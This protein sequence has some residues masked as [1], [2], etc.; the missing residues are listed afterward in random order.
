MPAASLARPWIRTTG[1]RCGGGPE[2]AAPN[3]SRPGFQPCRMMHAMR[4]APPAKRKPPGRLGVDVSGALNLLGSLMLPLG[5]AFLFPAAIALG[6]G[7]P[8]WPFVLSGTITSSLG[9]AL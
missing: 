5:L 9:F 7:E 6:Y 1:H 3:E 4:T 8:V 2:L